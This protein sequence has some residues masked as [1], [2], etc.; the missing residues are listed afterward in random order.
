[1]AIIKMNPMY[2]YLTFFRQVVMY[3]AVPG[4]ELWIGCTVSCILAL[5]IGFAVFRKLQKNFILYL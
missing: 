5:V 3:G 4:A 2:Y 1:M